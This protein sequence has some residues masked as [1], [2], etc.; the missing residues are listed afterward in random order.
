MIVQSVEQITPAWLT[1]VLT[2]DGLL[3]RGEVL[4]I[5]FDTE[6]VVKGLVSL[7]TRLAVRYSEDVVEELPTRFILKTSKPGIHPE[8]L[9]V[10]RHE[11]EFYQAMTRF[12]DNPVPIPHCYDAAYDPASGHSYLLM[13]D[14]SESHFQGPLPI[15][16]S[17]RHC[18]LII[19]SLA[20]LH[21]FW[22]ANPLL[23][24][25]LGERYT[26]EADDQS[27][28]RFAA[29][30][31]AFL[32][33]LGD[34]LL[35]QH[36]RHHERVL[37]SGWWERASRR[38]ISL[39]RVTLSHG[40]AHTGNFMLPHDTEHGQVAMIDWQLWGID[41]A[42]IDLAFLMALHW[43]PARRAVLEVPLLRRYHQQLSANGVDY[44]WES[45]WDDYRE[46]VITMTLIPVGQFRRKSPA[47][48]IWFG[49]QDSL[50]AFDDLHCEDLL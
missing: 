33:Y 42:T 17:N 3:Q 30:L 29:T 19:D 26:Q 34:G 41:M 8:L 20:H 21:A 39:D 35:P 4:E 16:P 49:L 27:R 7:I 13:T 44:P 12:P 25:G 5:S 6:S 50:A 32:D 40:D 48:V 24:N 43:S 15:P 1:D 23:G 14:L 2:A 10:G 28:A 38:L 37:A 46:A 22:W 31:P 9:K 36:K 45:L 47:G 18:E 11:M